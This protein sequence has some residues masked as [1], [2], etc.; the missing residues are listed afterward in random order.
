MLWRRLEKLTEQGDAARKRGAERCRQVLD[1]RPQAPVVLREKRLRLQERKQEEGKH[2]SKESHRR[3]TAACRQFNTISILKD[4]L[5]I[6][7]VEVHGK[8]APSA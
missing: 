5:Q 7:A 8:H 6:P 4:V 3:V 1:E 2:N